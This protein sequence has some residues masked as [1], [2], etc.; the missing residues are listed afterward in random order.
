ML[1]LHTTAFQRITLFDVLAGFGWV[2]TAAVWTAQVLQMSA[3]GLQRG[4]DP[5]IYTDHI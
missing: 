5:L 4:L 1:K 3:E 2:S